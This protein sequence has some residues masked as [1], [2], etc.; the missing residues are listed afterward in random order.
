[1]ALCVF[2][3]GPTLCCGNDLCTYCLICSYAFVPDIPSDARH[4][5][6]CHYPL[7]MAVKLE[8]RLRLANAP[9]IEGYRNQC[10]S[11]ENCSY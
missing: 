6:R 3:L 10:R 8:T 9:L 4:I 11:P 5:S 7:V 1:M 2:V